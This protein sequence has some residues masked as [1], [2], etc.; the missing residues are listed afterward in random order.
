MKYTKQIIKK[1]L[2]DKTTDNDFINQLRGLALLAKD[3]SNS[4]GN[5][6]YASP[7]PSGAQVAKE[8]LDCPFCGGEGQYFCWDNPEGERYD[9]TCEDCD[10]RSPIYKTMEEAKNFWNKRI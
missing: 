10:M 8:L 1:L 7:A 3:E 5:A 6:G 2:E 4:G 9:I